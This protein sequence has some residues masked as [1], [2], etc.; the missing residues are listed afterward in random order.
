MPVT[1]TITTPDGFTG[2]QTVGDP[3]EANSQ[4]PTDPG[5]TT[6]TTITFSGTDPN[7][8]Y[9]EETTTEVVT[10]DLLPPHLVRKKH[11]TRR[12][13]VFKKK[14]HTEPVSRLTETTTDTFGELGYDETFSS[15]FVE[16]SSVTQ[17]ERETHHTPDGKIVS[18]EERKTTKRPA[19]D[20]SKKPTEDREK[21][22]WNGGG[23]GQWGG[24]VMY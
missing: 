12:R 9:A 18:G 4:D 7:G 13:V 1:T 8:Q 21:R 17:L 14:G 15:N 19:V 16:G 5:T 23:G 2:Q 24:W 10:T 11:R 20:G 3:V 6:T 22:S